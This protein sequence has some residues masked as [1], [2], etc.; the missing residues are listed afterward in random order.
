VSL[1]PDGSYRCD[2]C[3]TDVDN[4]S[5]ANAVTIVGVDPDDPGTMR[6]PLHLCLPREVP[7]EGATDGA[8]EHVPGCRDRVLTKTALAAFHAFTGS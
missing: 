7:V 2:K 8:T 1:R 3:D 5:V 6:G 4:G